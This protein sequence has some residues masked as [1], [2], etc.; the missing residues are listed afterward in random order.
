MAALFRKA[1][2][3]IRSAEAAILGETELLREML[4]AGMS[5]EKANVPVWHSS[6]V[7]AAAYG[8]HLETVRLLVERGASLAALNSRQ[9]P[10]ACA[11][12][13]GH[14]EAASYLAQIG[15]SIGLLE[16][17]ML[18]ETEAAAAF[19]DG[20]ADPNTPI[21]DLLPLA[22]AAMT[23]Q[24]DTVRMLLDRGADVF[25]SVQ[26]LH[27]DGSPGHKITAWDE[28]LWGGWTDIV[29]LLVE[30]G[31]P[32]N[33]SEKTDG[34]LLGQAMLFPSLVR[35][36]LAHG[37]DPN[38]RDASGCTALHWLGRRKPLETTQ[39]LLDAGAAVDVKDDQGWT[40]LMR[41]IWCGKPDHVRLLLDHG[42]DIHHVNA[43]GQSGL[44]LL[45]GWGWHHGV[46]VQTILLDLGL[47]VNTQDNEGT[48]PLMCATRYGHE[49]LM[50]LYL[51]HGADRTLRNA[52][53]E[54]AMDFA[55]R[56][57]HRAALLAA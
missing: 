39:L 52:K 56:D 13:R 20:G 30:C 6:L 37:A 33:E 27:K 48:T 43:Q 51:D 35:A 29:L 8:G 11:A 40:P 3:D 7:A 55:L 50:Q 25:G 53:G 10:L 54:T 12:K 36:L 15:P 21:G 45:A 22:A 32:V 9:T 41:A 57:P 44:G 18:G 34:M 23:G 2:A 19:L 47:D 42:A 31:L 1:G 17:V 4:D 14:R 28:A 16:A 38:I 26:L 24:V 46:E 49:D 5:V